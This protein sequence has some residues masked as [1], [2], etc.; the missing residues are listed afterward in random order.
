MS[1]IRYDPEK[2]LPEMRTEIEESPE[3]MLYFLID[4]AGAVSFRVRH[5]SADGRA[6]APSIPESMEVEEEMFH[7]QGHCIRQLPKF[8]VENPLEDD[9]DTPTQ[10]YW[11]WYRGWDRHV[12]DLSAEEWSKFETAMNTNEDTYKQVS[13]WYPDFAKQRRAAEPTKEKDRFDVIEVE[14]EGGVPE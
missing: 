9:S 13:Q 10:E 2:L 5:D 12:K 11:D 14:T 8:G 7:M 3:H 4:R 6:Y 1:P